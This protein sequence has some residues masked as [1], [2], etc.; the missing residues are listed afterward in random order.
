MPNNCPGYDRIVKGGYKT[1]V[2]SAKMRSDHWQFRID[3]NDNTDYFLLLAFDEDLRLV[4]SWLIWKNEMTRK[5][6]GGCGKS[7]RTEKFYMRESINIYNNLESSMSFK[8]FE[9]YDWIGKLKCIKDVQ[10][11]LKEL[12]GDE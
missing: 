7:V 8:Y 12:I 11:K 2:K 5:I 6:A 4:H 10:D 9:K 1:D 3:N